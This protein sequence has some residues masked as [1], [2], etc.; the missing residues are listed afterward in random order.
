M[1]HQEPHQVQQSQL[2]EQKWRW[3]QAPLRVCTEDS[4]H[5]VEDEKCQFNHRE[6]LFPVRLVKHWNINPE[7][8]WDL[9]SGTQALTDPGLRA[10]SNPV[11]LDLPWAGLGQGSSGGPSSRGPCQLLFFLW[12]YDSLDSAKCYPK[13]IKIVQ[14]IKQSE[15]QNLHGFHTQIGKWLSTGSFLHIGYLVAILQ[16][17]VFCSWDQIVC[18]V[19]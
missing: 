17:L 14:L 12:L 11:Q 6:N 8:L 5:N 7:K 2:P 9:C 19:A 15:L 4:G 18:Y 1:V 13:I 16:C 10:Q 3:S